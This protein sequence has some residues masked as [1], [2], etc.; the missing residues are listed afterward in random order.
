MI[1]LFVF[2]KYNNELP[3]RMIPRFLEVTQSVRHSV[4]L[5]PYC[6]N[7]T[8]ALGPAVSGIPIYR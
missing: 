2:K 5:I 1:V 6:S 8:G 4:E 7:C 3:P